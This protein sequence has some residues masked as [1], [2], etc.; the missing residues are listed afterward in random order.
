MAKLY[1]RTVNELLGTPDG[2]HRRQAGGEREAHS[3]NTDLRNGDCDSSLGSDVLSFA[4][5]E[6]ALQGIGYSEREAKRLSSFL[7]E[8]QA[9]RQVCHIAQDQNQRDFEIGLTIG[10]IYCLDWQKPG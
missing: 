9:N 4:L 7:R 5:L 10:R 3:V 6:G 2:A 8:A 1:G